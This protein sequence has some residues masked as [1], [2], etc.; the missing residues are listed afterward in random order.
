MVTSPDASSPVLFGGTRPWPNA[1]QRL[2]SVA[3]GQGVATTG[4]IDQ[5]S[6]GISN[7]VRIFLTRET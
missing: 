1:P 5:V 4:A 7:R 2:V 6:Q 3:K